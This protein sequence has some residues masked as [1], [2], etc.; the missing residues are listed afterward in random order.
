MAFCS[1]CGNQVSCEAK[2]CSNCGHRIAGNNI[3]NRINQANIYAELIAE[4]MDAKNWFECS[5]YASKLLELDPKDPYAW[6]IKMRASERLETSYDEL[7]T[8]EIIR[9][10]QNAIKYASGN[11][12]ADY[13]ELVYSLFLDVA[14]SLMKK[15]IDFIL[16]LDR[17]NGQYVLDK[18]YDLAVSL[19]DDAVEYRHS[20]PTH[21]IR[22]NADK[23]ELF[24]SRYLLF[25]AIFGE[26]GK[27][28][29]CAF[30]RKNVKNV[31]EH[32]EYLGEFLPKSS[33]S[34][35]NTI[36]K[37]TIGTTGSS[38]KYISKVMKDLLY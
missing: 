7:H 35:Y 16:D 11:R 5:R 6:L 22:N 21:Y 34:K 3:S 12:I 36:I 17:E 37:N 30:S 13:E 23:A 31:V 27:D 38:Y 25:I 9:C 2:F 24:L 4:A 14:N 26:V 32:I 15:A 20:I 19:K 8:S 1:N 29:G 28:L 18:T 33:L 10:G